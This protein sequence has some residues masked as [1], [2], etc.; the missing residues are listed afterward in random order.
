MATLARSDA[1]FISSTMSRLLFSF[2]PSEPMPTAMPAARMSA[3]RAGPDESFMF[4]HGQCTALVPVC[5]S[6]S[7]SR[8]SSHTQWA[9]TV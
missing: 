3:T 5:A 8:S 1:N 4:E 2:S 7:I 6:S 9:M